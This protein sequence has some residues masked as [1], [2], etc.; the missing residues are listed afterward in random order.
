ML[1]L[2][3]S[4]KQ[5][6]SQVTDPLTGNP[7]VI[8]GTD[9]RFTVSDSSGM[10]SWSCRPGNIY[11]IP[12]EIPGEHYL[13][14]TIKGN[15]PA[16]AQKR[17]PLN[18]SLVLDRSG[19]MAGDKIEYAKRA[20]EFVVEQL[21]AEDMLSIVNY[22]DHIEV[23]S[24]SG[25]VKNKEALKRKIEQLHDRGATNLTG[26]MLE[27][28]LQTAS[29]KKK[30]YVNR[31][32]LLTDGLANTGVTEPSEIRR[33]VQKKYDEEGIALSTFGLGADYNE[34][35]LTMLAE[36]GRANYYFIGSPDKIPAIFASEM[37]GLL[38]VVA[39]NTW[40]EIKFPQQLQCVK[41]YGYPYEVKGNTLRVRFNDVFANDEK[42]FLVKFKSNKA[43]GDGIQFNCK[44]GYTNTENFR[45]V[46]MQ[47]Q[48]DLL[49]TNDRNKMKD[50]EDTIVQEMI[51]IFESAEA[52]DDIMAKVDAGE[53]EEAQ[54]A[55]DAVTVRLREKR[56][57]IRSEKL[58]VQY[59]TITGYSS[60][61]DSVKS[62]RE[63]EKKLYQKANKS[64]NYKMKKG[65]KSS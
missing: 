20:A 3:P 2:I 54:A 62:M 36:T 60:R 50:H 55:A 65:K 42:G 49:A 23:T 44:L 63:E 6:T 59:E 17:P 34:D 35:L 14:F 58:D 46:I 45:E 24:A 39:Q 38:S 32:L 28:Y 64:E 51:A 53:Y 57:H 40:L 33:L 21:S 22:D 4:C 8:T 1:Y 15:E 18:I 7:D 47:K 12:S 16:T 48:L 43:L 5:G 27:G 52:F 31:V 10:L 11:Y 41:A 19:S 29:T 25:Y 61:I 30:G 9:N 26:G 37:K 56:K 13:Y